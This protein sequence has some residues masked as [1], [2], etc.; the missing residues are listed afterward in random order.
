MP[1]STTTR[2]QRASRESDACHVAFCCPENIGTPNLSFAAQYLACQCFATARMTRGRCGSLSPAPR[3][4]PTV[5]LLPVYPALP[6]HPISGPS[7][8]SAASGWGKNDASP[9]APRCT[10]QRT[11]GRHGIKT[12][13]PVRCS[14]ALEIETFFEPTACARHRRK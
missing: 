13:S 12:L 11:A 14:V 5:Y 6:D 10:A 4:T 8:S 1:G 7:E 9:S 2:G 3:R